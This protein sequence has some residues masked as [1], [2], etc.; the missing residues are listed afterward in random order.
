MC[1]N[2]FV[3]EVKTIQHGVPQGSVLGPILF[4]LYINDL[5]KCIKYSDTFHFAD[6]TNLLHISKDYKTLQNNVNRDLRSLNE[7]LLANKISLN[8]DKTELIYFRKA[9]SKVPTNLKIKMN[10]KKLYHSTKIKY[11]GIYVDETLSGNEH[12]EDLSK[13]LNCANGI[14][15]KARH[16]PTSLLKN[17]YHATFASNLLYGSQVWGQA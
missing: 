13:K 15:A 16:A 4:L 14:L 2:G 9:R 10:G 5:N 3:S 1:V 8:K 11:L 17:I 6:N 12:S 7:W